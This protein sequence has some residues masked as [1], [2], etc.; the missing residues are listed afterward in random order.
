MSLFIS[1]LNSG[2]NGNCYYI[3][4]QEEAVLI[5]GGISC[6][7]T[8]KRMKRLGLSLKKVKAIFVSHEHGDHIH[9]VPVLSR[10]HK[11]PVY[12]TDTT[13]KNGRVDVREE[14]TFKLKTY[15]PV[16]IGSLDVI[17]FPKL[18]DACDPTSFIIQGGG[19]R[20]GVF[21]DIGKAC[22][23]V[24]KHFQQ[25]HAAFLETNY[26]EDMLANGSYPF[27]LK[28]R[29]RGDQGHLSNDQALQLFMAHRPP[30]MTHLFLSHLSADNN[31]PKIVKEMFTKVAGNTS[32]IV[33]SRKKETPLYHIRDL[34]YRRSASVQM[35]VKQ[36]QLQLF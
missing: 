11:I 19:V 13:W 12:M 23:H 2:S 34:S 15:Q 17:A 26:D 28:E 16:S 14:F 35:E 30:Y 32:I 36:E 10:K 21:T 1:S 7:E 4:N 5:D 9:G 27:M 29:I 31:K 22:D 25:C 3:G 33:A 18:H 24:T 20:I 8:E 6:R